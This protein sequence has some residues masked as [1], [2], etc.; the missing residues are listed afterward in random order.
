M[1]RGFLV[2]QEGF[3]GSPPRIVSCFRWDTDEFP[4]PWK[5]GIQISGQ[6]MEFSRTGRELG[7]TGKG[8]GPVDEG[9][10]ECLPRPKMPIFAARR[11]SI[12][13]CLGVNIDGALT[14]TDGIGLSRIVPTGALRA[15]PPIA[16][17]PMR[18]MERRFLARVDLMP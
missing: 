4:A 13:N 1:I 10:G 15:G 5:Q 14:Q 12:W 6:G 9:S 8:N 18:R 11:Q 3:Q 16:A 7:G 17:I 2:F